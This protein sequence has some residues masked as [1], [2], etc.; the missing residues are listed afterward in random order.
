M[1]TPSSKPAAATPQAGPSL[2]E[3]EPSDLAAVRQ[4]L[5]SHREEEQRPSARHVLGG[6][7]LR[8]G[9]A[10]ARQRSVAKTGR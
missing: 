4:F 10:R 5:T 7:V 6:P 3:I 9:I 2:Q 8:H 1:S